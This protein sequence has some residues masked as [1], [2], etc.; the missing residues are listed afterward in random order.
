[1]CSSDLTGVWA[2]TYATSPE[3]LRALANSSGMPITEIARMYWGKGSILIAITGLSAGLGIAIAT[4][5]GASRVLFSMGRNGQAPKFLAKLNPATQV[6]S[7]ALA[8]IFAA[9]LGGAILVG[10]MTSPYMA[11]VWW[12]TTTLFFAMITYI[13]VNTSNLI[14]NRRKAFKS[15]SGLGL[16]LLIPT[17]GIA[18]DAYILYQSFFVELWAQPWATGK[19]IVVVDIGCAVIA[20]GFVLKRHKTNASAEALVAG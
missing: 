6:P 9:G 13:A 4:S 2:L 12:G 20:L 16:Y 18:V 3:N 5:V 14:L 15:L 7:S 19:S 8:L 11:Y 17:F 10:G 1:M